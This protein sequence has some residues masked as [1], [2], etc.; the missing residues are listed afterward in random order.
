M[1]EDA[2]APQKTPEDMAYT[3]GYRLLSVQW[4]ELADDDRRDPSVLLTPGVHHNPF[5]GRREDQRAEYEAWLRGLKDRLEAPSKSPEEILG[6]IEGA[7]GD[8]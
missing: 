4:P 7:L 6:D 8:A 3:A 5:D 1:T 2:A